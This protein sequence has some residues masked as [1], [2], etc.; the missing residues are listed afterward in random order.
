[1]TFVNASCNTNIR[2]T[3]IVFISCFSEAITSLI[4]YVSRQSD[5]FAVWLLVICAC[6]T[7]DAFFTDIRKKG[8]EFISL[9]C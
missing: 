6:Q 5:L 8:L 7:G 9:V 4:R 3:F 1:M 2:L